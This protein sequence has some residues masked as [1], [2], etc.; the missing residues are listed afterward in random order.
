MK[1]GTLEN[2]ASNCN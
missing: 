1:L 2:S